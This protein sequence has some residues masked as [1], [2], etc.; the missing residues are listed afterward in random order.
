MKRLKI[1]THDVEYYDSIDELPVVR[2]HKW[3]KFLLVDSGI[4]ADMLAF[5][6]HIEKARRYCKAGKPDMAEKELMNL[7]QCVYFVQQEI[8]PRHLAFAALVTKIDGRECTDISD[9]ALRAI[10]ANFADI[11]NIELTDQMDSVKKKIDRELMLYF[12]HLFADSDVK[13]YFDMM[14]K[15]TM[16]VLKGIVDGLVVPDETP[17]VEKLNDQIILYSNPKEFTGA[18]GVEIQ[19]DKQFENMCLTLARNLNIDAKQKTVMEFY[20]AFEYLKDKAKRDEQAAKQGQKR[21]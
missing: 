20:N 13:E 14:R 11:S 6:Q 10:V 19:F 7:R 16:L 17:D 18:D 2:F 3:Q 5:D 21:H 8:N 15:R 12:P 1:G 4:G 9:D